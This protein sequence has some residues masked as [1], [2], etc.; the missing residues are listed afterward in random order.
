MSEQQDWRQGLH[1]FFDMRGNTI[2]GVPSDEDLCYIAGRDPRMWMDPA[3]REDLTQSILSLA[4]MTSRSSVLEVGSA[5][6]FL[7]QFIAPHVEKFTG[8]DLA[9]GPLK[10]ARR[11]GLAN[12]TFQK[13]EGESLPFGDSSFDAVFCYDVFTNFP[14]F[15]DG[16]PLIREMLRVVKPGGRV[17]VG[18]IPDRERAADLPAHVASVARRLEEKFGPYVA[19]PESP[20]SGRHPMPAKEAKQGLLARLFGRAKQ[21]APEL[22]AVVVPAI[23][24]FDFLRS[25]FLALGHSLATDVSIHEIHGLNPYHSYRFN[26]VFSRR[27][28]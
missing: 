22:G 15:E 18:S 13:A 6:G 17:L 21:P 1:A 2:E 3:M 8:V 24:T 20:D 23:I 4:A 5:A 12:A 11:L 25:D 7:A 26:A 27:A 9:E 28:G 10:V 16:S 19:R 14:N